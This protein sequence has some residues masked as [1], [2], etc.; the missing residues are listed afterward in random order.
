MSDIAQR[1]ALS[2]LTQD[3]VAAQAGIHPSALSRVLRGLRPP[4]QGFEKRVNAA[5]DVLEAAERAAEEAR[6]RVLAQ[7]RAA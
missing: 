4:P 1:I 3:A 5:L 6:S 2:G 7:G